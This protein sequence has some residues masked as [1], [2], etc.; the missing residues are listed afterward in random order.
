M[1]KFGTK[2]KFPATSSRDDNSEAKGATL[3]T[4]S[5]VTLPSPI[6]ISLYYSVL[7]KRFKLCLML[8]FPHNQLLPFNL[9]LKPTAH[10]L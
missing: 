2:R 8:H 4:E 5:A 1:P 3:K 10:Q 7:F 6:R 9:L